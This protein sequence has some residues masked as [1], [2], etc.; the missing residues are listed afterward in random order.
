VATSAGAVSRTTVDWHAM[1]WQKA[2]TMVRR[3]QARLVQATQLGRWGKVHALQ[4]LLTQAFSAKVLAVKRVTD[5]QG[6][7]TAG[8]EKII[9]ETPEQ[10]ARAV[11][12]LRQHGSR[13]LPLRRVYIPKHGG[14]GQR[15]R[16]MPWMQDRAMQALYLQALAPIAATLAEPNA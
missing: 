9:W 1:H 14:T 16:S 12:T 2:H 10:Q 6:K 13:A 11:A 5:N 8:V 4:R 7:R 3:L 15:P